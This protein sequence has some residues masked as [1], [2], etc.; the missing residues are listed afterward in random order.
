M[1]LSTRYVAALN[2]AGVLSNIVLQRLDHFAVN[3]LSVESGDEK[4][5]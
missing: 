4:I 2:T 5:K 3:V 1:R